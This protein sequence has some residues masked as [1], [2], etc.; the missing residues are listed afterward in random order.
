MCGHILRDRTLGRTT[1]PL[2]KIAA[3]ATATP[4]YRFSQAELLALAGYDDP[5]RRGFFE[6][7]GIEGRYLYLDP[8]TFRPDETVDE[9][10]ARFQRGA[11]EIAEDAARRALAR[12][13]WTAADVD[14]L[15]TTT[16]TGR[17]TPSIDAHLIARLG[18][19]PDVQ[20]VHVG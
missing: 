18:C 12:A 17:L 8:Q 7:S 10:Q 11:L 2:P 6:K 14:F 20:R 5:R 15:A 19:R 13:G 3:V 16:C 4:P 1:M 9:M